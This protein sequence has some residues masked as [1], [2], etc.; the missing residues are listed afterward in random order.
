VST[1]A[2]SGDTYVSK[3]R[4][5]ENQTGDTAAQAGNAVATFIF[6]VTSVT[7]HKMRMLVS[8]SGSEDWTIQGTSTYNETHILFKKLAAT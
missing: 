5:D 4:G 6:D 1:N 3:T 7:T 8:D 2:G